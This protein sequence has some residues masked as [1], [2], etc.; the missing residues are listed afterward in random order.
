MHVILHAGVHLHADACCSL[1]PPILRM[2][3]YVQGRAG[4]ANKPPR[5]RAHVLA[6]GAA[7]PPAQHEDGAAMDMDMDTLQDG[8]TD[9]V[10]M[11][12]GISTETDAML[13]MQYDGSGPQCGG[14]SGL[15][16]SGAMQHGLQD[17]VPAPGHTAQQQQ[18]P[19]A[20]A[21]PAQLPGKEEPQSHA[22]GTTAIAASGPAARA[23]RR[24]DGDEDGH[25]RVDGAVGPPSV[26]PAPAKALPNKHGKRQKGRLELKALGEPRPRDTDILGGPVTTRGTA[27]KL[28]RRPAVQAE[29]ASQDD[30][31]DES[32]AALGSACA[33][34]QQGPAGAQRHA[35]RRA[36]SRRASR[37]AHRWDAA[38]VA[39]ARRP[40]QQ[41]RARTSAGQPHHHHAA[42][43]CGA[44]AGAPL[45]AQW[46]RA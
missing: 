27:G 12:N 13:F 43:I 11:L 44:C 41:G 35:W 2:R 25:G 8:S 23:G 37:V 36:G 16:D 28:H 19:A 39:A 31:E 29:D 17:R 34:A 4:H 30:E 5:R 40:L 38:T 15:D 45:A 10:G 32:G 14:R 42:F 20:Q 24:R 26:S 22:F 33:D 7:V 3:S 21:V 18:Q 46:R 9:L 1:L 6:A